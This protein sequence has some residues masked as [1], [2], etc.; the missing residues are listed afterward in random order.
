MKGSGLAASNVRTRRWRV[1][2]PL[3]RDG[4]LLEGVDVLEEISGEAAVVL[5]K[6]LRSVTLWAESSP[7]EQRTLFAEGARDR[8]WA[9]LLSTPLEEELLE[10]L[11]T[12]SAVL[13]GEG[14][15]RATIALACRRVAQ[16]AEYN[17]A[18]RTALAF[19]QAAALTSPADAELACRVGKLALRQMQH[20]RAESWYRR[21]IM[22][23]RQSRD[24]NAYGRAYIGLGQLVQQRGN[25]PLAR[26]TFVRALR[27]ARRHTLR[28]LEAMALHDLFAV[29]AEYEDASTAIQFAA[30]AL[31]AYGPG[32]PRRPYLAHDVCCLWMRDGQFARAFPILQAL[33]PHIPPSDRLLVL[34]N[35]ARAAGGVGDAEAVDAA[36]R[37]AEP[38]LASA[39]S[40]WSAQAMLNLARAATGVARWRCAEQ[41]A[42]AALGAASA[43]A[44][45]QISFEAESVLGFVRSQ[46]AVEQNAGAVR[47]VS[48][49]QADRLTDELL[50]AFGAGSA[51]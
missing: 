38:L 15:R 24:W 36:W 11:R 42:H 27:C 14:A 47:G 8:R 23:A 6:T 39:P 9:D 48:D 26:R 2:P 29:T 1:P 32:H 19:V 3:T 16:W 21:A 41:M 20:A 37:E 4:E 18:P 46:R 25:L 30:E 45:S 33:V 51:G 35:L 13:D 28:E 22:L 40:R 34:T 49:P 12:L 7:E 5:W 43:S 10:P 50:L 17:Q 44:A 31:R